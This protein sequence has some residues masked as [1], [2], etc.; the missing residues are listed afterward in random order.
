MILRSIFIIFLRCYVLIKFSQT[1][2]A[3]NLGTSW[4]DFWF[5]FFPLSFLSTVT[6]KQYSEVRKILANNEVKQKSEKIVV[7]CRLKKLMKLSVGAIKVKAWKIASYLICIFFVRSPFDDFKIK[8]VSLH[9]TSCCVSTVEQTN[10]GGFWEFCCCC[11]ASVD[12]HQRESRDCAIFLCLA[13]WMPLFIKVIQYNSKGR[14]NF[15]AIYP[16]DL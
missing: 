15:Y 5:V 1:K 7:L 12:H 10:L 14:Q 9:R 16:V 8:A 11:F 6:L 2:C 4:N 3:S 13:E